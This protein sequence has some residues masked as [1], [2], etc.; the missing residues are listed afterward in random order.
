MD[1]YPANWISRVALSDV[2]RRTGRE[3]DALE[4]ILGIGFPPAV[5]SS[6]RSTFQE[7]GTQEF[8]RQL[9]EFQE[10]SAGKPCTNL[11]VYGAILHMR[12]E[13]EERALQC[14]EEAYEQR[15]VAPFLK[16]DPIW[17]PLRDDRRFQAILEGMGL[18]D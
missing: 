15:G 13:N 3:N 4:T 11:A 16:V 5:E 18:A 14:L 7:A 6:F 8:L 10:A 2:Y 1:L 9:I 17:D 12:I